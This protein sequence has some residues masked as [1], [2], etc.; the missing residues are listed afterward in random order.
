MIVFLNGKFIDEK[1]A[2]VS[3]R[4]GG[5]LTGHAVY[6]TLRTFNGHLKFLNKHMDRLF[7]SAD[8]MGLHMPYSKKE[9]VKFTSELVEK[10][11][12]EI[13]PRKVDLRIRFELTSGVDDIR[14]REIK[15]YTFLITAYELPRKMKKSVKVV[16]FNIERTRPEIK[17][18]SMIANIL[19]KKYAQGNNAYESIMIDHNGFVT[20]GA[21]TNIFIV[22]DGILKTP[23]ENM[24]YGITREE[25]IRL[26]YG[27]LPIKECN[28]KKEE[29]YDADEIFLTSSVVDV[30]PV[31]H[32]DTKIIG[33]GV[34][35]K[36]TKKVQKIYK[37]SIE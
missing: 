18:T 24:L 17:S 28:I 13:G 8:A 36:Y 16:T 15:S 27:I 14:V 21:F 33:A 10:R 26:A 3:I 5:F 32:V 20:E 1:D 7:I 29:L 35:G 34:C 37:D 4:D 12:K 30:I 11:Y 6:E 9:I 19:C 2:S 22:K 25:I 23:K 31:T